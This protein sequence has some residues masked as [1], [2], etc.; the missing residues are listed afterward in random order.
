MPTIEVLTDRV[1]PVAKTAMTGD[2]LA[3]FQREPDTW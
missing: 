3:R 2:I 1:E